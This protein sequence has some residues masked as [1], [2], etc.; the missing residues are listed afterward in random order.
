MQIRKIETNYKVGKLLKETKKDA[1]EK[2]FDKQENHVIVIYPEFEYQSIEGFG[3]A[4]TESSG[5][6]FSKF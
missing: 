4:F 2:K 5:Y 1:F 3:G 6:V